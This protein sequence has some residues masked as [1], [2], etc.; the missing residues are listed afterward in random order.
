MT[1]KDH[2]LHGEGMTVR[3]IARELGISPMRVLAIERRALEK[4]RSIP[5]MRRRLAA[6]VDFDT[7]YP[8]PAPKE[9]QHR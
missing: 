1:T 4:L 7:L 9:G 8:T 6:F 5:W 3:Q 2:W